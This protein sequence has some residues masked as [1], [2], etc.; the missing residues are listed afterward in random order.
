MTVESFFNTYVG[1]EIVHSGS[2]GRIKFDTP[3]VE[4]ELFEAHAARR[5]TVTCRDTRFLHP[6][7]PC[8][9]KQTCH[10]RKHTPPSIVTQFRVAT[11]YASLPLSNVYSGSGEGNLNRQ[12]PKIRLKAVG[13]STEECL[14]KSILKP[15][16]ARPQR[17]ELS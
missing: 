13:C 8:S 10:V 1:A 12:F 5:R 7:C 17:Q 2:V 9:R 14:C 11:V 6:T 16:V 4:R 15:F 3:V